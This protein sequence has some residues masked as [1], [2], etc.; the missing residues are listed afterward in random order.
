MSEN[1]FSL[2]RSDQREA[3]L[4]AASA[5][6]RPAQ[7]LEKDIWVV[8]S[9]DILFSSDLG[10]HLVFKGGTALSKVYRAI[11]RFSED[12]DLTYDIYQLAPQL[13]GNQNNIDPLPASRS[14]E[15]KWSDTI[16]KDLLPDWIVNEALPLVRTS[17]TSLPE[18]SVSADDC[19]IFIAY[20]PLI[21]ASS[22]VLPRVRL[23]F[24]ARSSGEPSQETTVHSDAAEYLTEVEFPS[25]AP[26]TMLPSRVFWEKA[27][28][29]HVYCLQGEQGISHRFSRHF[30]D[31]IRMRDAGFVASALQERQTAEAV[32]THK[33]WF[34]SEKDSS[35]QR[36]D[37]HRAINGEIHLAP[38]EGARTALR[39]DYEAMIAEG[40]F[41]RDPLPFSELM[42]RCNDLENEINGWSRI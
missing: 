36:I 20:E 1:Y 30:S 32:A 3:L 31:L 24:G 2:S 40:L 10:K 42:A 12:I 33:N 8:R 21:D 39:A 41:R 18:V 22:Y 29:A 16:R 11:E 27:T 14:Q 28:A 34:F 38:V 9:L 7:L 6:G 25:A 13:V 26:R 37:Y 4:Q 35:G 15:K 17:L 19:N 5:S 23:E